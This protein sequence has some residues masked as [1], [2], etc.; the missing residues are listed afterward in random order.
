LSKKVVLIMILTFAIKKNVT[1][2]YS[3][4]SIYFIIIIFLTKSR[5]CVI[6]YALSS[7]LQVSIYLEGCM[8]G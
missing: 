7:Y 2:G 3:F 6:L 1:R 5:Y 8:G 4:D